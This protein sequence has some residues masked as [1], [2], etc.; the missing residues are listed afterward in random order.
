MRHE[1]ARVLAAS[2]ALLFS[3]VTVAAAELEEITV[4]ARKRA[5]PIQDVPIS[6]TAFD[7]AQIDRIGMDD[8]HDY[9]RL[10]PG[11]ASF[12]RGVGDR[13]FFFRGITTSVG[14]PLVQ[15][16]IDDVPQT[17]ANPAAVQV[18]DA[19][20][21]LY[22]LERIEVLRGPQNTLF[23]SGAMGGAIRLITNKPN[24][25]DFAINTEVT[26]STTHEGGQNFDVNAMLNLPV[27]TDQLALRA[28]VMYRNDAGYI[29]L[30]PKGVPPPSSGIPQPGLGLWNFGTPNANS[31]DVRGARASALYK[32]T[33]RLNITGSVYWQNDKQATLSV[34]DDAAA[35]LQVTG[36]IRE[37]RQDQFTQYNL[38]VDYDLLFGSLVSSTSYIN[39]EVDQIQDLGFLGTAIFG[40]TVPLVSYRRVPF[41]TLSEELRLTSKGESRLSYTV[42]AYTEKLTGNEDQTVLAPGFSAQTGIPT[43]ND[44]LFD[45]NITYFEKQYSFFGQASYEL[46]HGLSVELGERYFSYKIGYDNFSD[47]L[48]NG[49]LS[50]HAVNLSQSGSTP[51][52]GLDYKLSKDFL[53]FADATK[54][55]RI[56]QPHPFIPASCDAE[57]ASLGYPNGPPALINSDSL[58][59]YELGAK[60]AWLDHRVIANATAYY[61][62][63][64]NI[65]QQQQLFSCGFQITVNIGKAKSRGF[66]FEL[67]ATPTAPIELSLSVG[68]THATLAAD[69]P[70]VGGHTGDQLQDVPKWTGSAGAQ[71]SFQVGDGS[72]GYLRADYSYTGWSYDTFQFTPVWYRP[73]YNS[74]NV[75]LGVKK[76]SWETVLF[77]DNA[78]NV[79]AVVGLRQF[80]NQR[81]IGRPRTFGLTV[82]KSWGGKRS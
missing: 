23:G 13:D 61:I 70:T 5:E 30:L 76:E 45:K 25:N 66:E 60:T 36:A 38:T 20:P 28:V 4:T 43:P 24:T 40:S 56:A 59:Q 41:N 50:F 3:W 65:P 75:R 29:D 46:V 16:Y 34:V 63:W 19:D 37:P 51:K 72:S 64:K 81:F 7:S 17:G 10:A 6:I 2:T 35:G 52:I 33:D 77:V 73:S 58:W 62:D 26:G 42:G 68:Y 49:G 78:T 32:A 79:E 14:S 8:F 15:I 22:D 21:R 12:D 47:G 80:E 69:A 82:R 1:L 27:I 31:E 44:T 67:K 53:I 74:L 57:L 48:F 71:Y 11:L 9:Q 54:G 39:R 55:F 18:R